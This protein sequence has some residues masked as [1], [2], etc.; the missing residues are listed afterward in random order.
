MNPKQWVPDTFFRFY[1]LKEH[2]NLLIF[3]SVFV[4]DDVSQE[5]KLKLDEP[6]I[7]A[8]FFDYEKG[9]DAGENF[10][11]W[12]SSWLAYF[13][14][15]IE[16]GKIYESRPGWKEGQKEDYPFE[17]WKCFGTSLISVNN[18]EDVNQKIIKPL[19][20]LLPLRKF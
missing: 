18:A 17:S 15:F 7:S 11:Y 3:V 14:S 8:G 13:V 12:Y 1:R 5:Y 9:K 19:M 20:D 6:L 2:N 10:D 4:D 16:H